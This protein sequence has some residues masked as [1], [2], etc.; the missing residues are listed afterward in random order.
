MSGKPQIPSASRPYPEFLFLPLPFALKDTVNPATTIKARIGK[1]NMMA[2]KKARGPG[3]SEGGGI[4][5]KAVD[6]EA[7]LKPRT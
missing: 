4:V 5:A 1:C 3:H 2:V 7:G 6:D